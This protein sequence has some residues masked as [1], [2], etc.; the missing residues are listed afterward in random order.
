[1][2]EQRAAIVLAAGKGKRM[3]SDLPKVLH[4]IHG[5]SMIRM[6]LDTIDCSEVRQNRGGCRFQR[7]TGRKG[8]CR[9]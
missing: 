6:V 2:S 5:R 7:R 4:A 9:L 8:G 3:K 1:M